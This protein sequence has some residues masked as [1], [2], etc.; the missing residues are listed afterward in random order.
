MSE[1]SLISAK[2]DR[3]MLMEALVDNK[4][5]TPECLAKAEFFSQAIRDAF[6][7]STWPE[8]TTWEAALN[9]AKSN[10]KAA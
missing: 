4:E 9:S 6:D 5:M 8:Q 3:P 1:R 2:I 7:D 10:D